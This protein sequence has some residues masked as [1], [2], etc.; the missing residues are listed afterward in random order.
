MS[1]IPRSAAALAATALLVA[2]VAIAAPESA[3]AITRDTVLARGQRWVNNPVPYSQSKYVSGYRTDCSGYVSMVWQTGRSWSTATLHDVSYRIPA[4]ELKP[5][6]VMLH[7]G[8]HVRMFYGWADEAHTT[9]VAY[10]QTGPSTKSSIKSF[11]ADVG[12]GYIPYRYKYITDSP[13]PWNA[14]LNPSFHVWSYGVPVWWTYGSSGSGNSWGATRDVVGSA[15]FSLQLENPNVSAATYAEARQSA[16]VEAGKVYTL[17][18]LAGTTTNPSAVRM[19]VIV[20]NASGGVVVDQST[21]GNAWGIG[22]GALKPMSLVVAMPAGATRVVTNLRLSGSFVESGAPEPVAV[23]DDVVL[24]V[25][26]PAPV[27]RF[28]NRK[29]G[30]HFYTAWPAERDKVRSKLSATYTYE[31]PAYNVSVVNVVGATGVYRFYN[32]KNGSHFYTSG[33][34][35]R[36]NVIARYAAIYTYEGVAFYLAP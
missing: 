31:G 29:N 13:A 19:R 28:Y 11:S 24:Y 34:A 1:S 9:Y 10:E 18:T 23:F 32:R 26:S 2:A 33:V 20:Y 21:T 14:L 6:D 30:S 4:S 12:A 36:D 16:P 25:S 27:Y 3:S 5:G 35:E 7:A 17:S 8:S 15:A 22:P